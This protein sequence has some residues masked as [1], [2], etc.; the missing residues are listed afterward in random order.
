MGICSQKIMMKQC[1]V[2][3]KIRLRKCRDDFALDP[4]Q[5]KVMV[6]NVRIRASSLPHRKNVDLSKVTT[7][8]LQKTLRL[9]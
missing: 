6:A 1:T 3:S 7:L 4:L 9:F 8:I 2:Q 5:Y